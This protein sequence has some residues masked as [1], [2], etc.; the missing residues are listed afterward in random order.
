MSTFSK[1][2]VKRLGF[3]T[4]KKYEMDMTT[5]PLLSKIMLFYVPLMLSGLLQLLFN[6]ADIA[7]LG[8]FGGSEALAAVGTNGSLINLITNLFMGLSVGS[9]VLIARYYGA[10]QKKDLEEM[11]HTTILVSL[12]GGIAL[13]FVGNIVARPALTW[14]DTPSDVIEYAV[15][16]LKIYCYGMPA[17]MVYNFGSA[18]LRAVG[19]TKRP[20]YFLLFSG[21]INV[22]LNL[23][24]VIGLHMDVDGVAIATVIS[25]TIAA[26]LV[27]RCLMVSDAD[28]RLVLSKLRIKKDKLIR[29]VQIGVP[30]GL[31]SIMFNISN[32]LIQS[33]INSFGMI[34]MAGNAA[35]SNLEGFV[36]TS[37]NA[38]H[39]TCINFTSQNMGANKNDRI[40]KTLLYCLGLVMAVGLLFGNLL[41]FCSPQ[42]LKI[43]TTDADAIYYGVLRLQIIGC[44][45]FLCGIMDVAVGSIRGLGYSV[46]PMIVS[47]TGVCIFRV[48]WIYGVFRVYH[49]LICLYLSY[50]ISWIMTFIAHMIC[51]YVIQKK[52][53]NA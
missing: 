22:I 18:I 13:I 52:R 19:D 34:T 16:Y 17:M 46:L 21:V 38:F 23:I 9:N 35:A 44:T 50:P 4:T 3:A 30:A 47:L 5:G 41:Y 40:N 8:R 29:M 51:F 15:L 39:Q 6:A 24:F 31:Q 27:I 28:Y 1:K 43:Y 25:Q 32:V 11:V 7:V 12:I 49:T 2:K 45:Y 36:Y 26:I 37:M 42:L 48:I 33:S 14:M 10:N 20:L 53:Q